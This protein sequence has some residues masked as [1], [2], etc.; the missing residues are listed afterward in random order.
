MIRID[1]VNDTDRDTLESW[2]VLDIDPDH[3]DLRADY[4]YTGA[5][6]TYLCFKMA[7]DKGPIV[8][9]RMDKG[10]ADMCR[11]H[12]QFAPAGVVS[13]ERLIQAMMLAFEIMKPQ[14]KEDGFNGMITMTKFPLLAAWLMKYQKFVRFEQTDNYKLV[15][16]TEVAGSKG[17]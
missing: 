17:A 4:W 6:G 15:F 12:A 14:L 9:V 13:K 11:F 3:H 8:Y 16:A 1:E 2:S 10:D 7:D 5:Y